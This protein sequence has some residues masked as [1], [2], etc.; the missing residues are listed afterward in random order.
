V[1]VMLWLLALSLA[2][3]LVDGWLTRS[4][5]SARLAERSYTAMARLHAHQRRKEVAQFKV[6]LRR[7]AAEQ[8]RRLDAE[9]RAFDRWE[10]GQR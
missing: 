10:R 7:D 3:V 2:V 5:T 9:L 6:E 1:I 8:R 4:G